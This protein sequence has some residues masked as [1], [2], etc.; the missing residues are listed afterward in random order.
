MRKMEKIYLIKNSKNQILATNSDYNN[1]K[2]YKKWYEI[3]D[4]GK[5]KIEEKFLKKGW[6]IQ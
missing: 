3:L 4:G 5:C 6:Q 1:A 2:N